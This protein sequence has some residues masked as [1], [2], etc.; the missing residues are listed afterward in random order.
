VKSVFVTVKAVLPSKRRGFRAAQA[1]GK[2]SLLSKTGARRALRNSRA[3]IDGKG[4]QKNEN[5]RSM[6]YVK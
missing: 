2:G 3:R 5:E 4:E 1:V 6:F